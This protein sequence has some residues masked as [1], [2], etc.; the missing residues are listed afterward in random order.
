QR[1]YSNMLVRLA[2]YNRYLESMASKLSHELRTPI[3]VVKS[4]LENI[5]RDESNTVFM[6]RA[7]D[8]VDRLNDILTRMSEATR[9]EN[10]LQAE[11]K[12]KIN[13]AKIVSGCSEGYQ[14]AH[15]ADKFRLQLQANSLNGDIYIK[16]CA[17]LIAQLLDKL[18][19]NALD[20]SDK[21]TPV[22]ISLI[23]KPSHI[24]LSV[25]NSGS[26]LPEY[27]Q[28]NLFE[29]MVSVREKPSEQAHL[30]LG[31]YIVRLIADFHSAKPFARNFFPNENLKP[32]NG[33]IT[34]DLLRSQILDDQ[35]VV[36]GVDFPNYSDG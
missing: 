13:I 24:T 36:V 1:S 7:K 26:Q 12:Q 2:D 11:E 34:Q 29:S 30:G 18:V 10:S 3:T 9:L 19:S 33:E 32:L 22:T 23:E 31:L 16:G 28:S 35:G 27:M 8:G 15:G 20:F 25:A 14:I 4:S 6:E 21:S 17:E 5:N